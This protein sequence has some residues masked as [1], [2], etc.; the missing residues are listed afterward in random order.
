MY[1]GILFYKI[2]DRYGSNPGRYKAHPEL[3]LGGTFI[4]NRMKGFPK[5]QLLV[6]LAACV[7]TAMAVDYFEKNIP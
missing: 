7:V 1:K 4:R 3:I 5:Y 6:S 2:I